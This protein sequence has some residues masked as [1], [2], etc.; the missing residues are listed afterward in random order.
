[1]A[2]ILTGLLRFAAQRT[3]LVDLPVARSAH[4]SPTP[5]GGGLAIVLTFLSVCLWAW[6]SGHMPLNEMLALGGGG[7]I[8]LLGLIDDRW[9]LHIRWRLPVQF[10]AAA[11]AVVWVGDIAP[12]RF[13][14]WQLD[15][16]WVLRILSLL[17]LIWLLNLYNFM[18]G[19]DGLAGSE[20]V[21]IGAALV[22]LLTR[23]GD[24]VL[25][26]LSITLCAASF[27][28]LV[29]NWP[30]A[31]IF[32]G[33][34]GSG[35]IG[36]V[37]GVMALLG[38]S[39]DSLSLWVWVLL[40]G[41]FITDATVTLLRRFLRGEKWYEG[42]SSHAY[43]NAARCYGSHIK[44]TLAVILINIVWLAPLAWFAHRSPEYGAPLALLGILPIGILVWR[45]G[46]GRPG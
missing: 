19:I 5:V 24:P 21:F 25:A 16:V 11:W 38:M 2:V 28:F 31:R 14:D 22:F 41:V 30:P 4:G 34:V 3:G 9:H 23:G 37:L 1:M 36:Y 35:F 8:A 26:I 27:G 6:S 33:D 18:D 10:A 46:A 17:A 20:A 43:Q 29:W 40:S 45:M 7:A 13:M 15:N 44:P 39:H 12:I 42:H 32:M